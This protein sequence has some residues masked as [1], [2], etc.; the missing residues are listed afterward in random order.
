LAGIVVRRFPCR[1]AFFHETRECLVELTFTVNPRHSVA[2]IAAS[3]IHEGVHAR[4]AARCGSL[5]LHLRARE[6]R[7]C[8]QAELEFGLAIPDGQV[9]AER[10]RIALAMEDHDVAPA[11]DW[12]EAGRRVEASDRGVLG[13]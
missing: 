10:A 3:I 11:V 4:L 1:G 2:E 8:R 5:G 9:V 12:G 6:E 13:P 7:L